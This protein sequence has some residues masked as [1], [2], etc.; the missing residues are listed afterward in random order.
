MKEYRELQ[1]IG[2]AHSAGFELITRNHQFEK[3]R[4]IELKE[5]GWANR[6]IARHMGQG[7]MAIR[8]Y[9]QEWLVKG[10]FQRHD[11][12]GRPRATAY[13][14][15]ILIVRSAVTASDSLLPTIRCTT[16]T[17]ASTITIRRRL[18][19]QNLRSYR[20]L[21]PLPFTPVLCRGRLQ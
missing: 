20:P 3:G 1:R 14:D 9:W 15:E 19:E 5:A 10:G 4:I 18:I 2:T 13:Q 12:S 6:T 21:R 7:D 17:R 11:G 16:R 8:R